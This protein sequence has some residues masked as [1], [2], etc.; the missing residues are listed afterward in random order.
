MARARSELTGLGTLALRD[1]LASGA[2]RAV[3]VAGAHLARIAEVEPTVQ[4]LAWADSDHAMAEAQ[5]LDASR[6]SGRTIGPLHGVPVVLKDIID[7]KGIPTRN[8]CAL[9]E[10]RVPAADS[11]VAERL[12]A[13]GALMIGKAHTTELAFLHP[14]PTRNPANPAHTPGGSSA[15]SAAAVAAGMATLGVGTQTG[16][17]VIRPAA[18]CGCV[19]F[20]PTFGAIPRRGILMQSPTLDTV[21]VF[22]RDVEGAALIA[23]VLAG[24][25]PADRATAPGPA[26][27]WLETARAAPPVRPT[28]AL[29]MPPGF[30]ALAEDDTRAAM[31][32]LAATLGDS[33][34][35]VALPAVFDEAAAV[36]ERINLAEMARCYYPYE[37]RGWDALSEETRAAMTRGKAILAR[38]Y[39]AALDWP[40]IL[41][42]GLAQILDRCDAILTP[43]TPGP[44]PEGLGSTGSAAFNGLWTLVGVP[45]VTIPVFSAANGMPMGLQVVGRRGD[46]GRVLR[47]ARWLM[48]E[49]RG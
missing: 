13:D 10:G 23:E 48:D 19:G 9:D 18:Y 21:G 6:A 8:G 38:D 26:P 30:E 15:G 4:A 39:I 44:A 49:L 22:A 32:E 37:R 20:K 16:G 29:V 35:T 12:K 24:H 3:E 1:G 36:R 2:L 5:R 46:D 34:F 42:A 11:W 17:S 41:H 47:T 7:T 33:A 14:A 31:A 45:V 43:A 27:R 28:F 25:D 40:D